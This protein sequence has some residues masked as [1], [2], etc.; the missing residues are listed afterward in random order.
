MENV[1]FMRP[2]ANFAHCLYHYPVLLSR[3]AK[4]RIVLLTLY[5]SAG[6]KSPRSLFRIGCG[7]P[8]LATRIRRRECGFFDYVNGEI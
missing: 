6:F 7:F 5:G 8:F 3:S 1:D 4:A 2:V